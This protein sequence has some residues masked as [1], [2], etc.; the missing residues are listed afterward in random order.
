MHVNM[1]SA[2]S[3]GREGKGC[4]DCHSSPLMVFKIDCKLPLAYF[5]PVVYVKLS[6]DLH[7]GNHWASSSTVW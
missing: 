2:N 5:S 7:V 1:Q 3:S 4:P 6:N